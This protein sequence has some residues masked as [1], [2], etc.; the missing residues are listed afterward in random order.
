MW[1]GW[2]PTNKKLLNALPDD[3]EM[4]YDDGSPW[5]ARDAKPGE[6]VIIQPKRDVPVS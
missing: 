3:L 1:D 6:S 2:S 5:R 4:I